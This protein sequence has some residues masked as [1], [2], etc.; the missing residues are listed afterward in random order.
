MIP[1][2][3]DKLRRN[4]AQ[5]FHLQSPQLALVPL[6]SLARF[7]RRVGRFDNPVDV[8]P[9]RLFNLFTIHV[10]ILGFSVHH[11]HRKLGEK[12]EKNINKHWKS[13]CSALPHGL[14]IWDIKFKLLDFR[15]SAKK[16]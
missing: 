8:H 9:L 7:A 14:S 1:E 13:F 2:P 11:E 5:P 3:I 4:A 6:L 12:W 16:M 15:T 10:E